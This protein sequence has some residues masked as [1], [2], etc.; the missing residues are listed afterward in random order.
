M[1]APRENHARP[2]GENKL[3]NDGKPQ[4][5]NTSEKFNLMEV[6]YP[7]PPPHPAE[8]SRQMTPAVFFPR[9]VIR[10]LLNDVT[11]RGQHVNS[12]CTVN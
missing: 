3:K 1:Q 9:N 7:P 5:K 8:I 2:S 12:T 10:V 4:K 11:A 6:D